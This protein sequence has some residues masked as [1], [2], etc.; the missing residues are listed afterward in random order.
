[1]TT[2]VRYSWPTRLLHWIRAGLILG[3]TALGWTMTTLPDGTSAEFE[4]MYPVHKEFG[5]LAFLVGVTA[6]VC[7]LRSCVP[8]NPAA[9][10]QWEVLLSKWV[11]R[12]MQGLA[13][14]VPLMGY[15]MSSSFAQSDG[16]P[17]F[18]SHL[19]ELL[20]KNDAAFA[21][22]ARLHATL[23][24]LLLTLIAAHV[25]GVLK[26]CFLDRTPGTDVL[27]RIL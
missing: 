24:Y 5:V 4:W 11:Q 23:A 26:H 14:V 19:P 12:A 22:F 8:G 25:L 18:V 10:A 21:V 3:L 27:H 2:P 17:F 7:R 9:L 6:I 13:I 1:M 20:P 16:V 15:A